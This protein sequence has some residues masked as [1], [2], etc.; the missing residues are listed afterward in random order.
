MVPAELRSCPDGSVH[1]GK[2]ECSCIMRKT[3][4]VALVALILALAEEEPHPLSAI[5]PA[6]MLTQIEVGITLAVT[7]PNGTAAKGYMNGQPLVIT[8]SGVTPGSIIA[9]TNNQ[10]IA[11]YSPSNT[12]ITAYPPVELYLLNKNAGLNTTGSTAFPEMRITWTQRFVQ[13]PV[14]RYGPTPNTGAPLP[15]SYP[16]SAAASPST[17]TQGDL[18]GDPDQTSGWFDPGQFLTAVLPALTPGQKVYYTV[19]DDFILSADMGYQFADGAP[20]TNAPPTFTQGVTNSGNPGAVA[21]SNAIAAEVKAGASLVLLNGDITYAD[22]FLSVWDV[23]HDQIQPITANAPF[24]ILNGNHERDFPGTND[25]FSNPVFKAGT[26]TCPAVANASSPYCITDS[27]GEC[28]VVTTLRFKMPTAGAQRF[29]TPGPARTVP[30]YYSFN[31][32]PVHF[33]NYDT[34]IP[35]DVGTPQ[36][37]FIQSD[38]ASVD[39]SVTPWIVVGGHRPFYPATN[40]FTGFNVTQPAPFPTFALP[41]FYTAAYPNQT[42]GDPAS[43]NY[44]ATYTGTTINKV[45]QNYAATNGDQYVAQR[46]RNALEGLFNK[47]G[48]DVAYYGHKHTYQR[49]FPLV[50]G[51]LTPNNADGSNPGTIYYTAGNAGRSLQG[52]GAQLPTPPYFAAVVANDSC[53]LQGVSPGNSSVPCNYYGYAMD[54]NGGTPKPQAPGDVVVLAQI[55]DAINQHLADVFDHP[56]SG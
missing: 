33:M 24:M 14:V 27:R 43:P 38:L 20:P 8:L 9:G 56:A 46:Q 49:T 23:F 19:G 7:Y 40:D 18:C 22:G 34:E 42:S 37:Q 16:L 50:G 13:T 30:T 12:D 47:Y 21:V 55:G 11:A 4:L 29:P 53:P 48:V 41:P 36:W 2:R 28:G 17:F 51:V 3:L 6:R 25:A 44:Y 15:F 5:S 54:A 31:Y 35:Y 39:R 45:L 52:A 1:S 32:G 26:L 10:Y